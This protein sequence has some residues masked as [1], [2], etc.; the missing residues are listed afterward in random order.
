VSVSCAF[1][2]RCDLE[3]AT[4]ISVNNTTAGNG[5]RALKLSGLEAAYIHHTRMI[6]LSYAQEGLGPAGGEP[7]NVP[8]SI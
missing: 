2:V 1:D 6:A 3:K 5:G 7:L 4:L 8:V